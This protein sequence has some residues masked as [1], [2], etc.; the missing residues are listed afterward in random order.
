MVQVTQLPV[1]AR[2]QVTQP[3]A[4]AHIQAEVLQAQETVQVQTLV[5]WENEDKNYLKTKKGAK[6]PFLLELVY[7]NRQ[8][9]L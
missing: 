8:D 4:E 2:V 9:L 3:Q 7:I 5:Q 1:E 6:L